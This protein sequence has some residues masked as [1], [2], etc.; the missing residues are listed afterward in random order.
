MIILKNSDYHSAP[1]R[2][3]SLAVFDPPFDIWKEVDWKPEADTYLCFT[4]YQ[5]YK[6]VIGLFGWPE[7]ELIWHFKDG[8]WVSHRMPRLTHEHILVYGR[9]K[10]EAYVG[11][12]TESQEPQK[13]GHACIGRDR[14]PEGRTYRPRSRKLLN[15][16]VEVP[17]NVGKKLGVW[18]KPTALILPLLEWL[19][20]PGDLVWDGFA[21]TAAIGVCCQDLGLC[22][23]GTELDQ[24]TF[25]YGLNRITGDGRRGK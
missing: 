13:K 10:N 2:R 14:F 3:V 16:V 24:G 11:P 4:N 25:V 15:S 19:C 7:V 6:Y 9:R 20:S 1:E 5:N 22:Y 12:S 17:R 21:G 23:Y 8:R 18:S